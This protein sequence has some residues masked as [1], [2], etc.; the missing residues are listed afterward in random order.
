MIEMSSGV[1]NLEVWYDPHQNKMG[2]GA[3]TR[4]LAGV[5]ACVVTI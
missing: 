4:G 5:G 3:A 2:T 1:R